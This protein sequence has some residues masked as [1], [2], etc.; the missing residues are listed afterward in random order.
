MD[1]NQQNYNKDREQEKDEQPR[2]ASDDAGQREPG[3]GITNR[4]DNVER[5]N[6]DRLPPRGQEKAGD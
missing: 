4:P 1:K 2:R 5:E 3:A 6:Q